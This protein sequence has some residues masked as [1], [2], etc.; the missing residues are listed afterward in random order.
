MCIFAVEFFGIIHSLRRVRKLSGGDGVLRSPSAFTRSLFV[1]IQR[2]VG[3]QLGNFRFSKCFEFP[4]D[5]W[6]SC[7]AFE[8]VV[9]QS[10]WHFPRSHQRCIVA[11][12]IDRASTFIRMTSRRTAVTRSMTQ[13]RESVVFF[14]SFSFP[15]FFRTC[16]QREMIHLLLSLSP[17]F[18]LRISGPLTRA[19]LTPLLMTMYLPYVVDFKA[20]EVDFGQCNFVFGHCN[21][22]YMFHSLYV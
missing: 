15:Q 12:V 4:R 2:R 11:C 5:K 3:R 8:G 22:M 20:A 9:L 19:R 6:S 21:Y 14:L 17:R 7:I 1:F 16:V 13:V 10:W 18:L